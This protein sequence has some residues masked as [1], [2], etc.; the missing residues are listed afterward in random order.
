MVQYH[1]LVI[2]ITS[3]LLKLNKKP[4]SKFGTTKITHLPEIKSLIP[5]AFNIKKIPK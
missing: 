4:D 3:G 1:V 2:K 5:I